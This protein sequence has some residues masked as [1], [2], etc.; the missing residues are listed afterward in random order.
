MKGNI[1]IK[2]II[3]ALFVMSI[4]F[5][6]MPEIK[7]E[8]IGPEAEGITTPILPA[9]AIDK[10]I[11][12]LED[13][14]KRQDIFKQDRESALALLSDYRK[15]RLATQG[16]MSDQDYRDV[17]L[18]LFN[19]LDRLDEKYFLEKAG[20]EDKIPSMVIDEL[21]LRKQKI[22]DLYLSENYQEVISMCT[23]LK[24]DFGRNS[25]T[26]DIGLLFAL[27][28]AENNMLAEAI[29]IGEGIVGELEGKPDLIHLRAGIIEWLL[30]IGEREKAIKI[31]EKLIDNVNER[32]ALF[33]IVRQSIAV[34]E[35]YELESHEEFSIEDLLRETSNL[36]E[37]DRAREVLNAAERL[38]MEHSY[39]EARLM[40]LRWR[41][42]IEGGPEEEIVE[43]AL[44]AVSQAEERYQN[45][46]PRKNETIEKAAKLI[47][48]ENFKDAL[49][50]LNN[51]QEAGPEAKEL[52]DLAIEKL[53]NS[54]RNRAAKLF[55][56]IRNTDDPKRKEDILLSSYKILEELI[57]TYPS[58]DLID[59]L[60]NDLKYVRD[61]LEKLRE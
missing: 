45:K 29:D 32:E 59:K 1:E 9:D 2:T 26:P 19:C 41:L 4:L 58:S 42:R 3:M 55:L 28:M 14:L 15:I 39:S 21:T 13:F 30:E 6:C 46:I 20:I 31:Y 60:K 34:D 12:M 40:L 35:E 8:K 25:L 38:I 43:R 57:E 37:P 52:R 22:R 33:N 16:K 54:E 11:Y 49:E 17:I 48:E 44:E 18:T 7:K 27:S 61:E 5:S 51:A 50:I 23:E 24:A 10:K 53:I 36:S 56:Q 47:E